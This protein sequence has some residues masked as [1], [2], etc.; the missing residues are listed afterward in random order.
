MIATIPPDLGWGREPGCLSHSRL[1]WLLLGMP[2]VS[3]S[4]REGRNPETYSPPKPSA[5]LLSAQ[6]LGIKRLR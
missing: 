4:P 2:K 5:S 6:G 1:S 3:T